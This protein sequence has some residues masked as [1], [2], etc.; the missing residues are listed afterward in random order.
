MHAIYR[1][2]IHDEIAVEEGIIALER[3]L[4][5]KPIYNLA[6]RM[7]IA[8]MCAGLIAPLG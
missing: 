5:A 6:T 1:D 7:C 8:A 3:L 4:K 2:V